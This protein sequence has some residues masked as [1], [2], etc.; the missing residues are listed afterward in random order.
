[1]IRVL[2]RD[3]KSLGMGKPEEKKPAQCM[4]T[5]V[6]SAAVAVHISRLDIGSPAASCGRMS[7]RPEMTKAHGMITTIG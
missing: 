5:R 1:V 4:T 3:V 7:A 2:Q 6:D